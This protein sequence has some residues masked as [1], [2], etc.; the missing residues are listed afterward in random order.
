M[1][2][3]EKEK[4]DWKKIAPRAVQE[5]DPDKLL[6]II[7]ELNAVLEAGANER[8]ARLYAPPGHRIGK[9]LQF[10]DDEPNI[11]LTLPPVL[12]QHGFQVQVA[13]TLS[14]ALAAIRGRVF[15]VVLSDLNINAE[16]DGFTVI[17]TAHEVNP[18]CVT[19]LL[20]GYPAF[21]TALQAIHTEVDDYFVKPVYIGALLGAIERKLLARASLESL[22]ESHDD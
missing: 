12:E 20:T 11:C 16:G 8:R 15:D 21:E 5:R 14:E 7:E 9:R 13:A 3:V 1:C 2:P 22:R 19:I 10:V 17:Y 6:A 4:P 18:A